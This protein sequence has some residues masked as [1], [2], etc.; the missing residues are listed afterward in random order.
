ML[1]MD[2]KCLF[3]KDSCEC[4]LSEKQKMFV[5]NSKGNIRSCS[6]RIYKGKDLS[7]ESKKFLRSK[8]VKL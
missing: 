1:C 8:G 6:S 7:A 5:T 2:K 3:H 4:C